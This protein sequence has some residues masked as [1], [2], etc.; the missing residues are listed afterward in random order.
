MMRSMRSDSIDGKAK[1]ERTVDLHLGRHSRR[2]WCADV[3]DL[4]IS[5]GRSRLLCRR[6]N[7]HHR[8]WYRRS[9][10][11]CIETT[12]S[13]RPRLLLLHHRRF[14]RFRL[15]PIFG[16]EAA[17]GDYVLIVN[18]EALTHN[19]TLPAADTIPAGRFRSCDCVAKRV[20]VR[21]FYRRV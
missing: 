1:V 10:L 20:Q 19:S 16:M 14:D 11:P 6:R 7:C 2:F 8:K 18:A 9:K 21:E 13:R 17:V 3:G 15:R 4:H 5:S 12:S